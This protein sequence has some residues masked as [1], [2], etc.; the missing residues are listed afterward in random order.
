MDARAFSVPDSTKRPIS[1]FW[2]PPF[3]SPWPAQGRTRLGQCFRTDVS[4]LTTSLSV[5]MGTPEAILFDG[6]RTG[7]GRPHRT[8]AR[9]QTG[10]TLW[11]CPS[12]RNSAKPSRRRDL[13]LDR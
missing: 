12:T 8:R 3:R 5:Y 1:D 4:L 2:P 7:G 6:I 9:F 10:P 11:L 13:T